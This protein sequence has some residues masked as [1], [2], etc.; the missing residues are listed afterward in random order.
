MWRCCHCRELRPE[1][2]FQLYKGHPNGW[3]R[4]CRRQA[5]ANRRRQ[6]GIAPKIKPIVTDISKECLICH[7]ILPLTSFSPSTRGR[8]G[9]S[10]YCKECTYRHYGKFLPKRHRDKYRSTPKHKALH[11]LTQF[12]RRSRMEIQSDGTVTETLLNELYATERCYYCRSKV[13]PNN[14]TI[15][16]RI[17]LSRGGSHSVKNLVMACH[18]CNS[19][20]SD[21]TEAEYLH[22]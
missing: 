16:H 6:R 9:R 15:D 17:P 3:C 11:R 5:E 4:S 7:Q 19:S 18:Q 13:D 2:D 22:L 20:K 8:L 10:A 1:G 21:K 14:R 12:R